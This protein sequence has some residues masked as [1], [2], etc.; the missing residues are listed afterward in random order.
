LAFPAGTEISQEEME[1]RG[2]EL[3]TRKHEDSKI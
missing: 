1:G 3:K 2:E